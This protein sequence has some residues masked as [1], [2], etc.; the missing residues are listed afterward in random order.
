MAEAILISGI[1]GTAKCLRENRAAAAR[2]EYSQF[3]GFAFHRDLICRALTQTLK[4]RPLH[5]PLPLAAARLE[6]S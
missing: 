1:L 4:G 3:Q 5:Q 2:L 6:F